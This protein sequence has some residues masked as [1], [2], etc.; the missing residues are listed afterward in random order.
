MKVLLVIPL[1]F[2]PQLTL[3]ASGGA[4]KPDA[5]YRVEDCTIKSKQFFLKE[6]DGIVGDNAPA[7]KGRPGYIKI[8]IAEL[9]AEY[10]GIH[11]DQ[12]FKC[13]ELGLEAALTSKKQDPFQ[14]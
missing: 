1:F 7:H 6:M 11:Y 3:A 4:D 2:I 12:L 8:L 13:M 10:P 5:P 9:S 14:A